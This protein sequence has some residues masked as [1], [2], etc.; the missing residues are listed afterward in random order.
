M[1]LLDY[2][3]RIVSIMMPD[4]KGH[5][6]D[7]VVGFGDIENFEKKD[8]FIGPVIGRFGNR[9]NHAAFTLDGTRYELVAN[10]KLGGELGSMPWRHNGFRQIR[11]GCRAE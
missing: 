2:G 3:A 8:R 1:Q 11:L 10:E 7:V 9:I 4:R 5:N 6:G